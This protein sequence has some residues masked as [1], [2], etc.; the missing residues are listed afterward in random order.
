MIL[1]IILSVIVILL[2]SK[3]VIPVW[4]MM[5][6][7]DR[8][9]WIFEK[10]FDI[11]PEERKNIFPENNHLK[12]VRCGKIRF[13]YSN[14]EEACLEFE[15]IINNLIDYYK[16]YDKIVDLDPDLLANKEKLTLIASKVQWL[17]VR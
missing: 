12:E 5:E 15:K 3:V 10:M 1:R 17:R 4:K 16:K 8:I 9:F 2:L 14:M 11:Y 6:R 7:T 13:S